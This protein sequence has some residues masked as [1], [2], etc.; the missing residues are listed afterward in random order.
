MKLFRRALA[1]SGHTTGQGA[2]AGG[3]A[4]FRRSDAAQVCNYAGGT[5]TFEC[6]S[7]VAARQ[8]MSERW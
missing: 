2:N 6:S 7:T 4:S 8:I 5:G 3:G 1:R